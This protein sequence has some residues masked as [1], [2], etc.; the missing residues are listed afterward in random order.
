MLRKIIITLLCTFITLNLLAQG[1][2]N[3]WHFGTNA[4]LDFN[5]G[6]PVALL[7][8]QLSTQEG[9]ATISDPLG[10]LLFYTDGL[11]V[12]D[13][14]HAV[15]P[16]GNG[17]LGSGSSTQS[18]VIVPKPGDPNI[19]YLFTTPVNSAD[20]LNYNE[21]DMTLNGGNGD[22]NANKNI[23][24]VQPV[25]EKVCAISHANGSSFWV[26]TRVLLTNE[27]HAFEV[28]STG[29]NT[30]AVVSS[31]GQVVT[32]QSMGIGCLKPSVDGTKLASANRSPTPSV[33][34]F[35]FDNATGVVSNPIIL[36][37]MF[38]G[39][40]PYGVE[41]S[42]SNQFIYVAE[43]SSTMYQFDISTFTL[44]A[45][46]ASQFTFPSLGPSGNSGYWSLQLGPDSVIYASA[47]LYGWIS[48]FTN[49][50]M[51]GMASNPV[52]DL[53]FL[54][55]ANCRL[56]LPTFVQSF[57]SPTGGITS[58]NY[59]FGDSTGINGSTN[60]D[61][62]IWNFDDPASGIN[63]TSKTLLNKH[64]FTSTGVY[65]VTMISFNQGIP[66][67][68]FHQLTIDP[69]PN[70][71]LG[72]DL[73]LCPNEKVEISAYL[74]IPGLTYLWDD[75]STSAIREIT[76][77][78]TYF[79]KVQLN[80]C[81]DS[82]TIYVEVSD[83]VF[84]DFE[85]KIDQR[86]PLCFGD[87]VILNGYHPNT[88]GYSWQD[89][90]ITDSFFTV[91]GPGT[92]YVELFDTCEIVLFP[93]TIEYVICDTPTICNTM[94]GAGAF[95]PNRDGL[96][97]YFRVRTECPVTNFQMGVY[98]RWGQEV[99]YTNDIDHK[100]WNG[101][102]EGQQSEVGDYVWFVR[103]RDKDNFNY[104]EKGVVTLIR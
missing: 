61:S 34:L 60:G 83:G 75:N 71:N 62:V 59:C 87:T 92:Y 90:S 86:L 25:A 24:L 81:E 53:V 18:G 35:D 99:Y 52:G 91:S 27:F 78:G 84:T 55:G 10:N 42:P 69:V 6:A 38:T 44:A 29:I 15:M 57:F 100:G 54:D 79:V 58:F 11:T 37:G 31:V 102:L 41:F 85:L 2:G 80:D 19:Y 32:S 9:C 50:N 56:G 3:I 17:L 76:E 64:V 46:T 93:I 43:G 45:I 70:V 66:D 22:I 98:N 33:G 47:H 89:S 67:T 73:F 23:L 104:T 88:L 68:T 8:G 26:I 20:G 14:N 39:A 103:F 96:N 16:N 65:D 101:R 13:R 30:T 36:S 12:Y 72:N 49:P 74:P 28:S 97:D 1:E 82:D 4:G 77:T 95:S 40:G 48:G 7:G 94:V 63:N 21:V 51:P 5:G